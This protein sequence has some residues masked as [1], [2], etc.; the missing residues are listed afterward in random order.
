MI[1]QRLMREDDVPSLI[2]IQSECYMPEAI[3]SETAIRARL[4]TSPSSAWVAEDARG[5]CA[6]LVAYPSEPGK[7][8]PLGGMFVVA[9][10]PACLY[11]HDLAVSQRV[12]GL[13]IGSGLVHLALHAAREQGWQYC[14]L[15]SVQDSVAFWHRF[16]FRERKPTD[17][18]ELTHLGTYPQPARYM[19]KDLAGAAV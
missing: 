5:V 9:A 7:V 2:A 16:G 11:L 12:A 10:A 17:A 18:I 19:V 6:Y 1:M 15:V 4:R 3:E 8:T 14:A 13:G